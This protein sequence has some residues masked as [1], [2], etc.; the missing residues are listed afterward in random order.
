MALSIY[1]LKL[2]N[3]KWYVG[4]TTNVEVREQQHRKGLGSDWTKL[5]A[6]EKLFAIHPNC[7]DFDEDKFTKLYMSI[8]G[9]LNVRGG[10]NCQITLTTAVLEQLEVEL[11][12][13]KDRCFRCGMRGHFARSCP[14][15][16]A[17]NASTASPARFLP[18]AAALDWQ[19]ACLPPRAAPAPVAVAPAAAAAAPAVTTY[20]W[21]TVTTSAPRYAAPAASHHRA[22][23]ASPLE[24][25]RCGRDSHTA[26]SC[27]AGTHENGSRIAATRTRRRDNNSDDDSDESDE[28]DENSDD[29]PGSRGRAPR[30]GGPGSRGRAPRGGPRAPRGGGSGRSTGAKRWGGGGGSYR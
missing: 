10:T 28:R 5:H 20:I 16:A 22:A 24:C 23:P 1:V 26:D 27:Y 8:Y 3:G 18:V 17:V 12:S 11:E 21:S 6:V 25:A 9:I 2:A 15:H 4:K 14:Q 29:G 19:R 7:D 30:G 13:T